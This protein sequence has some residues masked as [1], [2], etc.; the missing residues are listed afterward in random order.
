VRILRPVQTNVNS[1]FVLSIDTL[2]M[3]AAPLGG[4][5][6]NYLLTTR[7]LLT[8]REKSVEYSARY[9]LCEAVKILPGR[10]VGRL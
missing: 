6:I 10:Q 7:I 8:Y 2:E 1:Q 9:H 5:T 4:A 3:V